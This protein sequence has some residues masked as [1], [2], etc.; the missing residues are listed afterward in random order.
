M[1]LRKKQLQIVYEP[2][3]RLHVSCGEFDF[4]RLK[5]HHTHHF[6]KLLYATMRRAKGVGIAAPQVGECT[7]VCLVSQNGKHAV[8]LIN[9]VITSRSHEQV[10]AE[11]GCLSIPGVFGEVLRAETID[12][13]Y[14]N[15]QGIQQTLHAENFLARV[16]QHE[17][18]HLD[19]ILFTSKARNI[20][21]V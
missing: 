3:E 19:G 15:A 8:L 18:D 5:D 10:W 6:F 17:I 12:I 16:I 2:D 20:H 21:T 13:L 14:Y 9:P 11:E 1:M 4:E 7:R